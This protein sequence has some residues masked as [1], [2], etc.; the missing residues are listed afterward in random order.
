MFILKTFVY[1][2][3][4]LSTTTNSRQFQTFIY[5]FFLEERLYS[6]VAVATTQILRLFLS[7]FIRLKIAFVFLKTIILC[8]DCQQ[9]P[10]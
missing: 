9:Q 1:N 5:P 10:N 2:S 4:S 8:I 6:S 7:H 3:L